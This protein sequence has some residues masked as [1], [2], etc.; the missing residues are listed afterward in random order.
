MPAHSASA[1][2]I[3]PADLAR[4]RDRANAFLVEAK[5]KPAARAADPSAEGGRWRPATD[6]GSSGLEK[7]SLMHLA[8]KVS[9]DP[10][11]LGEEAALVVRAWREGLALGMHLAQAYGE[12][13]GLERLIQLNRAGQLSGE[14]KAEFFDKHHTSSAV[15]LYALAAYLHW[16]LSIHQGEAVAGRAAA[17][18]NLPE[19]DFANPLRGLEGAVFYFG[20]FSEREVPVR[21]GRDWF[22]LALLYAENLLG[23]VRQRSASLRHTEYFADLHYRL[24]G[25]DFALHGFAPPTDYQAVGVE[26]NRVS[27]GE[28]VGNRAAKHAA[29]RLA[30]RLLCYDPATKQNPFMELGGLP[31]VRMGYG[32]PGTG[33]SLQIAATATLLH[34]HC[35]RLGIP[36]LFWPLPDN[37]V[38]TFQGGSAERMVD[39]M[40]RLQDDD[41]ILY[42]PIDDAENTFEDRTREGVSAGVREVIGVFLR[43]TEGAYAI[44][45]GNAVV[46]FFTNLPEQLDKAVLSRVQ[47]RFPIDGAESRED[48]LDQD[49][50]W[51]RRIRKVDAKVVRQA[52]PEGYEYLSAQAELASLTALETDVPRLHDPRLREVAARVERDWDRSTHEFFARFYQGVLEVYPTFSS[53]DVRNIQQAMNNRL[54]DFD[55]PEDWLGTP[56]VFFRQDY[57]TKLAMLRELMRGNMRGLSFAELRWREVVRYC[58]NLVTILTQDRERQIERL[59]Q[60]LEHETEARARFTKTD[61]HE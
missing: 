53:R 27:F 24:E 25:T 16:F 56:E 36:F 21:D 22:R 18:P 44:R 31:L 17:C 9:A 5:W 33:K 61:H 8:K 6:Y 35:A 4:H 49:H 3:R 7:V 42:A 51:W 43:Y 39:Y 57:A 11:L 20:W 23:E 12:V 54:T 41:K 46:E 52:D 28:I 45:R 1:T 38:S 55:L 26:F 14:Q 58:N 2:P 19:V 34:E 59:V 30:E 37:V 13:A 15:A 40:R 29:R 47:D 32:K 60:R 48:F 50:L 10:L